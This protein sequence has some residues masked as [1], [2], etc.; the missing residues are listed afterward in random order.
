[1]GHQPRLLGNQPPEFAI[2]SDRIEGGEPQ[3]R[4]FGNRA[5]QIACEFAEPRTAGEIAAIA[6]DI[7][8][9]QHDLADAVLDH[10]AGLADDGVGG[11]A[12]IIAAA[13]RNDAEGAAVIATL[14]DLQE[15]AGVAR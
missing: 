6:C 11:E 9:G 12:A 3:A 7:H 1:M 15:A 5:Q 4:K 14:L 2:D 13:E 8:A 10:R